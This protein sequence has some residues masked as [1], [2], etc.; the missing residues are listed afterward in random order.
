A[1][2]VTRRLLVL[3]TVIEAEMSMMIGGCHLDSARWSFY[4]DG[5]R[6]KPRCRSTIGLG[7]SAHPINPGSNAWAGESNST[8]QNV[9]I[10]S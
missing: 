6:A 9:I 5:Y 3:S 10:Y 2:K 4:L 1:P 7:P 8:L